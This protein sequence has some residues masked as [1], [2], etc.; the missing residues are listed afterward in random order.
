VRI[1]VAYS[2]K[3]PPS[4]CLRWCRVHVHSPRLCAIIRVGCDGLHRCPTRVPGQCTHRGYILFGLRLCPRNR[5]E[6]SVRFVLGK[7]YKWRFANGA[8]RVASRVHPLRE[9]MHVISVFAGWRNKNSLRPIL[10]YHKFLKAYTAYFIL[11]LLHVEALVA[12]VNQSLST[13]RAGKRKNDRIRGPSLAQ[14]IIHEQ[15]INPTAKQKKNFTFSTASC[16]IS[17]ARVPDPSA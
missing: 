6:W 3:L 12:Q 16:V 2:R 17:T 13:S 7:T 1:R 11:N 4:Y 8:L 5:L 14:L 15:I 9:T 10:R